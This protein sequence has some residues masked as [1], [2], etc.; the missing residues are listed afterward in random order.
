MFFK[1]FILSVFIV[2]A[3]LASDCKY[4]CIHLYLLNL[5]IFILILIQIIS[6]C[7]TTKRN[8]KF[9]LKKG[10]EVRA[11]NKQGT[12][13]AIMR[14]TE[15]SDCL[16]NCMIECKCFIAVFFGQL[17]QLFSIAA[18]DF[19]VENSDNIEV[20]YYK[21]NMLDGAPITTMQGNVRTCKIQ[22]IRL[23]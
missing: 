17:C 22:L 3:T 8:D 23:A 13:I 2:T 12:L 10:I 4:F 21:I 20:F 5:N 7:G 18:K 1:I 19:L 11:E 9:V 15:H 16:T 14:S 6:A